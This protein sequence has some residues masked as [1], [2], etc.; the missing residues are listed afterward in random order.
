MNLDNL[1]LSGAWDNTLK[2]WSTTSGLNIK[3]FNGDNNW[4]ASFCFSPNYLHDN[5]ILSGRAIIKLNC[6]PPKVF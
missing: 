6:G 1:I 3:T 5:L 2:L 4:V